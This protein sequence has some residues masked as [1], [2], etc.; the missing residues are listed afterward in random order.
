MSIMRAAVSFKKDS[1]SLG[2]TAKKESVVGEANDILAMGDEG[3]LTG[4]VEIKIG[5]E[6]A[7]A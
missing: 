4:G 1:R 7:I 3:N 6:E 2:G 5:G